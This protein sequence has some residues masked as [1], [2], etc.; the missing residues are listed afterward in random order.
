MMLSHPCKVASDRVHSVSA[1]SLCGVRFVYAW[2]NRKWHCSPLSWAHLITLD[3]WL[4]PQQTNSVSTPYFLL[5][6]HRMAEQAKHFW[7]QSTCDK[8]RNVPHSCRFWW[9]NH[10]ICSKRVKHS[11]IHCR[12]HSSCAYRI[13]IS[14]R[15]R[16]ESNHAECHESAF[17]DISSFVHFNKMES[18]GRRSGVEGE[19]S[20]SFLYHNFS[21]CKMC[22]VVR[23]SRLGRLIEGQSFAFACRVRR[24]FWSLPYP[25]LTI[26]F[27]LFEKQICKYERFSYSVSPEEKKKSMTSNV[28]SNAIRSNEYVYYFFE[29]F[30]YCLRSV[31]S[32]RSVVVLAI[33]FISV[34][35]PAKSDPMKSLVLTRNSI[36]PR[37]LSS[38][39]PWLLSLPRL[40]TSFS[41]YISVPIPH[42]DHL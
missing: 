10:S 5:Y 13:K 36:L 37:S 35:D 29:V 9:W 30:R 3:W 12:I 32:R 24:I 21:V 39:C 17:L 2:W 41:L 18:M 15:L 7:N 19:V 28:K 20:S 31:I 38:S 22:H 26:W 34:H 25:L 1:Q 23:I 14:R 27:D 6:L 16:I 42:R 4:V 11:R 33:F 40:S 8:S